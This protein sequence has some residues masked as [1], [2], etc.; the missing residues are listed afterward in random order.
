[1]ESACGALVGEHFQSDGLGWR[2]TLEGWE[3][4]DAFLL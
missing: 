1:M 2:L 3:D 4:I